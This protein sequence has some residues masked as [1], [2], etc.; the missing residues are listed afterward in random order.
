MSLPLDRSIQTISISKPL[1]P[2]A[3]IAFSAYRSSTIDIQGRDLMNQLTENLDVSN[4]MFMLSFGLAPSKKL[5][6]GLNVKTYL[7]NF[8]DDNS[9][10]G[11]GLD[12]GFQVTPIDKLVF[13]L[14]LEDLSTEMNWKVAVGDENRQNIEKFPL[15][16]TIGCAYEYSKIKAYLR[17]EIISVDEGEKF[18]RTRIGSEFFFGPLILQWGAYQNRGEFINEAN[19][20]FNFIPTGGF[21][22]ILQD[23]WK[24]PTQIDYAFDAGRT[25]EGIGH[26]FT[27]NFRL[28]ETD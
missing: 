7:I 19:T 23:K 15:N 18:Y 24:I 6:L 13:A 22:V 17:Q 5:A 16:L 8:V 26:M 27:I 4:Y 9:A 12:L 25:G 28:D 1:P 11:I 10:N 2:F 3:G 14:K 20:D 21:G